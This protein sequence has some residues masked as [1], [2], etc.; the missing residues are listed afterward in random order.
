VKYPEGPWDF[1]YQ[2][3]PE[4]V[5][6]VEVEHLEL[7][8][9]DGL[10][11]HGLYAPHPEA[12]KKHL[13]WL[14][15][16]AGNLAHRYGRLCLW[17]QLLKLNILI[18]DYRGYGKSEGKPSERGLCIDA[19][20]AWEYLIDYHR[21]SADDLI[22]QGNSLGG[23]IATDLA[24]KIQPAGLILNA[25]FTSIVDMA[26]LILSIPIPRP[27]LQ[28]FLGHR[29]NSLSRI[30]QLKCP[31]LI[32]H[33]QNDKIIPHCMGEEL[34]AA[35]PHLWQFLSV[36]QVGHDDLYYAGESYQ[37]TLKEFRDHIFHEECP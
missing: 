28:L 17:S 25:T 18:I 15:G 26:R 23:A 35:T 29:M 2:H 34:A 5:D 13:L 30:N 14:H 31:V 3:L 27:L 37:T 24:R 16:N 32:A 1:K 22:I 21:I 12:G 9:R 8:T 11:L 10:R 19:E 20:T 36:P 33:G 6:R 7:Y 4:G